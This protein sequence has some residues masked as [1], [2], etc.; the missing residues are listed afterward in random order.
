MGKVLSEAV[1]VCLA[2]QPTLGTDPVAEYVKVQP[3]KGSIDGWTKDLEIVERNIHSK[4][5]TRED[6]EVIGWKVMPKFA[7]D[8]NKDYVD[9]HAE[10][11]MRCAAKHPGGANQRK[12]RITAVVDGGVGVDSFSHAALASALP[13]GTLIHGKGFANSQNNALFV[14][15][16]GS[17]TT[18]TKV[19]TASLVAEAGP[20]SNATLDV[21]GF[22]GTAGDITMDASGYLLSTTLDF[23]TL[24]IQVGS[25]ILVGTGV[26]GT[27]TTSFGVRALNYLGYVTAVA[28]HQITTE[29]RVFEFD[30]STV[31]VPALNNGAGKTINVIT[32]SYY[33]DYPIDDASYKEALLFGEKE[34]PRAGSDNTSR[35]TAAKN[36]AVNQLTISAPLKNK[37]T[38]TADYVGTDM[39][40]PVAAASRTAGGG[41]GVGQSPATAYEPLGTE[42]L[43]T[44]NHI[45]L[46]RMYDA[47]GTLVNEIN[48]WTL[49]LNNG[50]SP[51]EVQGTSGAIDHEWGEYGHTLST[52]A[53]YNNAQAMVAGA[54]N[55]SY[56]WDMLA[57]NSQFGLNFDL[58]LV[59]IRNPKQKYEA[60]KQVKL[61]FDTPALRNPDS[62]VCC[63][64]TVYGYVPSRS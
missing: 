17:T 24:G 30:P 23:T 27:S 39:T 61:T 63:A 44:G 29:R 52:E 51:K 59:K 34:D 60:N 5:M 48:S 20:P 32:G 9:L 31:W 50:V 33:R 4:N 47:T 21:C 26:L 41:G 18:S 25:R 10:P 28:A 57:A 62:G 42:M 43:H 8:L 14:V 40:D 36:L 11:M 55:S 49:T 64:L 2:P 1:G 54:A 53:Y 46:V 6:G 19:A 37:I 3:D 56:F 58:P 7:H 15:V 13:A 35:F 12:V 38:A 22:Q 45:K 16:A